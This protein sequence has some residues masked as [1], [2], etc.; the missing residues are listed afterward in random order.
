MGLAVD[1]GLRRRRRA[2][3]PDGRARGAGHERLIGLVF[4]DAGRG[5]A[6]DRVAT[7]EPDVDYQRWQLGAGYG[8][9]LRLPWVGLVGL[10]VGLPVTAGITGEPV[11]LYLTLGHSF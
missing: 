2:S 1:A 7:V 11:W 10:D 5:W 9:R 3:A 6:N 4:A 8:L